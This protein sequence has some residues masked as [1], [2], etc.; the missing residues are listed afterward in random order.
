MQ[1]NFQL[2]HDRSFTLLRANVSKDLNILIHYIIRDKIICAVTSYCLGL[3]LFSNI[4]NITTVNIRVEL[5]FALYYIIFI[6]VYY[7]E[8][9]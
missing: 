8:I 2:K 1:S 6:Q 7:F 4:L 5:L 3:M 9:N